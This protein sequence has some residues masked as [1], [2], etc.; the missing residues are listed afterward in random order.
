MNVNVNQLNED[1]KKVGD[2]IRQLKADK[3]SKDVINENVKKL[4][5]LK[6]Q[7]KKVTG[8][9]WAPNLDISFLNK[10]NKENSANVKSEDESEKLDQE[11]KQCS[12]VIRDLKAKKA[13]KEIIKHNVD[14]LLALKQQYKKISGHRIY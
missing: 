6:D 4:L 7:F 14:K 10:E 13:D 2:L 12:D 9:D 3:Q 8:K 11:I 5:D 1:I